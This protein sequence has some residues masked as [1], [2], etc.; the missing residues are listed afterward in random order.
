MENSQIDDCEQ[1]WTFEDDSIDFVH[2][3]YLLG[4]IRDWY[5]L[6]GQAFR[7]TKPGGYVESFEATPRMESDD[8]TVKDDSAHAQWG[9]LFMEG[10]KQIGRSFTIV[11]DGTQRAAM[12]KAG[13]VNIKEKAV[14]VRLIIVPI[15]ASY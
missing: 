11:D 1:S 4:S 12:E 5:N 7:C 10:G 9:R 8:K 6:L 3:R 15:L 14:K 13:F 2:L